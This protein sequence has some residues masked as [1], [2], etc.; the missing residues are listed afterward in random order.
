VKPI[1]IIGGGA[2]GMATALEI[3]LRNP[4]LPVVILEKKERLGKKLLAT[5]NGRCNISNSDIKGGESVWDFL[6]NAGILTRQ[7]EEGRMYPFSGKA[8]DVVERFTQALLKYNVSIRENFPVERVCPLDVGFAV[9]GPK[10][11]EIQGSKVVLATGGKAAPQFG[12]SGDGHKMCKD[13]GIQVTRTFP[14]LTYVAVNEYSSELA[15]IRA[16]GKATLFKKG[17]MVAMEQG[18][19]QFGKRG[20]SGIP[21]MNLSSQVTLGPEESIS[22]YQ[23]SL[24]FMEGFP[25][26]H[27]EIFL[28]NIISKVGGKIKDLLKTVVPQ[29]L[30]K[31]V[32]RRAGISESRCEEEATSLTFKEK[33]DLVGY[34]REMWWTVVGLGGWKDAQITIGGVALDQV[35]LN[36]WESF[37]WPGL[38]IVGELLDMQGPC[39]GYNLHLAWKTGMQGANHLVKSLREAL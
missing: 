14:G 29:G 3:K 20:L 2:S 15:G 28:E 32:F 27:L 26:E 30:A 7:E 21:L 11:E 1:V 18:E 16:K 38:Y 4:I 33:E 8:S 5:G 34:L 25:E 22:S 24:D 6:H 10:G 31:E 13:L 37:R 12:S 19:I 36:T 35:H 9:L 17:Q 39:G 23:I